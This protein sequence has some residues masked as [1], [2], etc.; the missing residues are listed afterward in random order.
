MADKTAP[1]KQ[2]VKKRKKRANL[3]VAQAHIRSTYNNTQIVLT[4][5]NG[6]VLSWST[7]GKLGFKGAKKSTPYAA[8]AVARD[9][10]EQLGEGVANATLDVFVKGIGSGREAAIRGL[11]GAGLLVRSITDVTPLPHNGVRPKKVRRV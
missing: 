2:S 5:A 11:I 1:T 7:S 3:A 9:A 6:G 8:G 10:V 4:D